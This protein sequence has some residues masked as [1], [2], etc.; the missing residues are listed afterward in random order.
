MEKNLV[1]S[2]VYF[3]NLQGYDTRDPCWYS[4]YNE[5]YCSLFEWFSKQTPRKD[6]GEYCKT[7]K[8]THDLLLQ[9]V[10][11]VCNVRIPSNNHAG[12]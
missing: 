8:R 5:A 12:N 2:N 7:F 10:E 6:Q 9:A 3:Y 4:I 1:F 11:M